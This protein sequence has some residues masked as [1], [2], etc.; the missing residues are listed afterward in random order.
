LHIGANKPENR[1][2][3]EKF[4]TLAKRLTKLKASRI[5]IFWGPREWALAETFKKCFDP[6]NSMIP[7]STLRR[8]A[9]HFALCDSVVCN[10]TGIMHLCASVGTP[11][12]GIFGPTDPTIWKPVGK[13]F[14]AV[15]STDH[16]TVNVK[17]EDVYN[18]VKQILK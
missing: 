16:N 4:C 15:R 1:W 8:Q 6:G 14:K 9:V 10:D 12:V 17:V 11:L 7:P 5:I 2:P 13:Q 3:P 18:A